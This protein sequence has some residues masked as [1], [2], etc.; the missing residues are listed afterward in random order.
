MKA[1]RICFVLLYVPTWLTLRSTIS[2]EADKAPPIV[3]TS[4]FDLSSFAC[5]IAQLASSY[6]AKCQM[7]D[8]KLHKETPSNTAGSKRTVGKSYE[9][10]LSWNG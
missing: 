3:E 5:S 7:R 8:S 1:I 2:P 4:A 10:C 6:M 9:D